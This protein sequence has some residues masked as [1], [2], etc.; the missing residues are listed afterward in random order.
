MNLTRFAL[1][2]R[3]FV[4]AATTV[5]MVFGVAAFRD[6]PRREDPEIVIRTC[7]V[8]T[9]WPGASAEKVEELVTDPI[10]TELSRIDVVE[11]IR[12][13]SRTGVSLVFVDIDERLVD[14][15]QHFDEVRNKID[16]VAGDL[17]DGCGRPLVDSD[18][19]DVDAVV[20]AL[21]QTP[22]PGRDRVERA[23]SMRELERIAET[24]EDELRAL[25][26]VAKVEVLGVPDEVIHIEV[27]AEHWG[28]I[29]LTADDLRRRLEGRNIVA[30]GGEIETDSSRFTV[31]PSGEFITVDQI[32][33]VLV[34]DGGSDVPI[35]LG[36]LPLR[37]VR[38]VEDP[39]RT[40]YRFVSPE[41]STDRA[42]LL[43]VVMRPGENV[44]EMGDAI[45]ATVRRLEETTLPPDVRMVRVNDLP[46]VVDALVSDFV[47]N[48]IQAVLVVL[49]V[50]LVMMGWR[51]AAIMSAAI[52]LCMIAS[53][54]VVRGFGVELEQFSIASLIIALGMLVDNA[55]V[56]C[57][58]VI[59]ELGA[60]GEDRLEAVIRGTWSL[61]TP[62]L[63]S[64]L[65][66]VAAF[67][68][69]LTIVG[70]AGEY[71]RSLPVVVATV[72]TVSYLVAMMV[73]PIL[74]WWI[75]RPAPAVPRP[76]FLGRIAGRL[77]RR[78][79]PP[80]RPAA[81]RTGWYDRAV[82]FCLAHRALT[83]GAAAIAVA[84]SLLLVPRIG[85][86]FFPGGVRD[87]FFVHVW[88]P[89]GSSI[90]ATES[91]CV[92]VEE[93]LR[94]TSPIEVDG[95]RVERLRCATSFVGTGGPRLNLTTN[96]EQP[97][98]CYAHVLVDTT[99]ARWSEEW[100]REL[101]R[102]VDAIP[103]A[104]IDVVTFQLGPYIENPIEFRLGGPDAD[105]LRAAADEMLA[106]FRRTPGALN[107]TT[108][109]RN[110]GYRI[111]VRVD[112]ESANLAGVSN[113]DVA[114]TM[115]SLLSGARLT[116]FR[117]GDHEVDV[118]LR[119]GRDG[120]DHILSDLASVHVNGQEGKVPL[121]SI[122][123]LRAGFEPAVIAR[124]DTVRTVRIGAKVAPGRLSNEIMAEMRPRLD[125]IVRALPPGYRLEE[126]GELEQT[127]EA[128]EK[129]SKAF[130]LSFFLILLVLIAQYD[131]LVKPL[132][133]LA[134][135]PL[136][137]IGA[138][139][140]LFTTGWA[141]GFMP[142]LGIISLAGVV[143]NNAIV[144]IDFIETRVREG[145]PVV[146]AIARAGA[147]R[148]QPILLTTSTTVGGL[149]PLALVG[150]PMWAGMAWAMIFGLA[151]STVLTLL[152]VPT[153]YA[154]AVRS[155][156]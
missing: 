14:I 17:P 122:A 80:R 13:E 110:D 35:R 129:L 141:L 6:M 69:M 156:A 135:V 96:P 67:L 42:L 123:E 140:G 26:P 89:E 83:L 131:G 145:A 106:V 9:R 36:D 40:K 52:P 49:L 45:A 27:D 23:Y 133:V 79:R 94:R 103:G 74:C 63:T 44:V 3:T 112:S 87:Q 5:L 100:A 132:V 125:E 62:L 114:Q 11:E 142:S 66:T 43:R 152:V 12:S 86:Q 55:I 82:R 150:G 154:V 59:R 54:L 4:L 78:G 118:V 38:E 111:D 75:L 97:S 124:L 107:P 64:T 92:E 15:D 147:E 139:L 18:F 25:D 126:G 148:M 53:L 28:R 85:S 24:V 70:S 138:L 33:D 20:L 60:R 119:I 115:D 77:L 93:I 32:E 10:E 88:L 29:G 58:N 84:G 144:L 109:W 91:V 61:A 136:A 137:L 81:D 127:S 2:H 134:T 102:E 101:R 34:A 57:D 48:L 41:L 90:R 16:R 151:L 143:I 120:R 31:K 146:D 37:V 113:L 128:Q 65:T 155:R 153:I 76:S 99:D 71:T 21:F 68:P 98:P 108:D 117:E 104:R 56:V 30:S 130:S 50:A 116:T 73:T 149:L 51:P 22:S 8:T 72:L 95:E 7:V 47:G 19:G 121:G 1:T 46:N 39:I 105:V